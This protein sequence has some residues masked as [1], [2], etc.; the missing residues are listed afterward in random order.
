MTEIPEHLLKRSK[1]A[2]A[3]ASGEA[4]PSDDSGTTDASAAVA[5]TP[6]TPAAA[7]PAANLP[8]LDPE[9]EP[10]KPVPAFVAASQLRKRIPVWVMPIIAALPI[11]AYSFAGTMQQPEVEDILYI[12]A[13]EV[14]NGCSSCHGGGGGGGVGLKL[15]DGEVTQTF[16]DPIDQIAHI[17]RGS[18]AIVGNEYGAVRDDGNRRVAAAGMPAQAEGLNMLQLELVVFHERV[19]LAGEDIDSPE[20]EE[21]MEHMREDI[22]SGGLDAPASK[23][24][25][26]LILACANPDMTPGATGEAPDGERCPGPPELED[27]ETAEEAAAS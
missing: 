15:S 3:K 1:A 27:E 9:P 17:A 26:E 6:K 22:E 12:D 24:N 23:D 2:K 19:V 25:L 21:W 11:W 16:P 20:Y 10:P 4:A 7:A 14:Y 18:S 13:A 5:A 8:N